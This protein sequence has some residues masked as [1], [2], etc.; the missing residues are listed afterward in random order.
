V[1]F[2]QE[3][4]PSKNLR[5]EMLDKEARNEN[6]SIADVV[7]IASEVLQA[8]SAIHESEIYH[9]NLKPE[10]ILIRYKTQDHGAK[11]LREIK[12]TDIMTASILGDENI[13]PS[14]YRFLECWEGGLNY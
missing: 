12:I 3:Y 8:L 13:K 2:T 6:F 1:F 14:P 10:N 7:E 5:Q 4:F 11:V 9:T